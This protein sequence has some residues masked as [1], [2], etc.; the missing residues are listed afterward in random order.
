[1]VR[2]KGSQVMVVTSLFYRAGS[3]ATKGTQRNAVSKKKKK[4]G[5]FSLGNLVMSNLNYLRIISAIL[6]CD[7]RVPSS[8]SVL[9]VF[10]EK[11][12]S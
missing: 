1:M 7:T 6:N 8:G 11:N 9:H 4:K 3:R 12:A 2:Y 10:W 5:L